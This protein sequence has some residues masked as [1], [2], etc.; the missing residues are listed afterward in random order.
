MLKAAILLLLVILTLQDKCNATTGNYISPYSLGQQD[1]L[2]DT[3]A[4]VCP[5]I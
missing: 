3:T 4:L 5:N 1:E 2:N